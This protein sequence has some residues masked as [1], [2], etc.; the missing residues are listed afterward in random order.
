[1]KVSVIIPFYKAQATIKRCLDSVSLPTRADLEILLV[2]DGSPDGTAEICKDYA[3]KDNRIKLIRKENGGVSSARNTGLRAAIGEWI[4]FVDADDYVS[5]GYF[6]AIDGKADLTIL[7]N[8]HFNSQNPPMPYQS[9]PE[10]TY[11]DKCSVNNFLK[12]HLTDQILLAP[13]GKFFRR[14]LIA[15]LEFDQSQ[16]LGEDVI[17]VHS[18]LR[19]CRKLSVKGNAKYYY[20]EDDS[21]FSLKYK[22][23]ASESL[24]HLCNIIEHYRRLD[25]KSAAFETFEH[26][27]FLSLCEDDLTKD[28]RVWFCNPF[29]KELLHS[30]NEALS[31]KEI[32]KY[33]LFRNRHIYEKYMLY[34]TKHCL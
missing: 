9:I 19:N 22:M 27:L 13:W 24:R 6:D 29:V 21:N 33:H 14:E 1:M 16:R 11:P 3:Q 5:S 10:K 12:E 32:I 25:V 30:C 15:D 20:Y 31:R 8:V 23:S 34:H 2:D 7:Q 26:G 28:S 4:T 17:F 18:Y